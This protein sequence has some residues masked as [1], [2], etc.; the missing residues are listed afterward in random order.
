M[1]S[2]PFVDALTGLA[3]QLGGFAAAASPERLLREARSAAGRSMGAPPPVSAGAAVAPR[4]GG[5]P[6]EM[7]TALALAAYAFESYAEPPP[8][9]LWLTRTGVAAA[10]CPPAGDAGAEPPTE[11]TASAAR[12]RVAYPSTSILAGRSRGMFRL[13]IDRVE[14]S[15]SH[16]L[17]EGALFFQ[18]RYGPVV[19]DRPAYRRD[20]FLY[21]PSCGESA[22]GD[23]DAS[24]PTVPTAYIDVYSSRSAVMERRPLGTVALPL[25]GVDPEADVTGGLQDGVQEELSPDGVRTRLI[26]P[27]R[28]RQPG[29]PPP[30]AASPA[31][32]DGGSNPAAVDPPAEAD[33]VV[34]TVAVSVEQA[35][36]AGGTSDAPPPSLA[37]DHSIGDVMDGEALSPLKPNAPR[38][39]APPL[40]DAAARALALLG[41]APSSAAAMLADTA[42]EA[43]AAVDALRRAERRTSVAAAAA[44]A[45]AGREADATLAAALSSGMA[46]VVDVGYI[47]LRGGGAGEEV[48]AAVEAADAADAASASTWEDAEAAISATPMGEEWK[49]L[50]TEVMDAA[51][52]AHGRLC[53]TRLERAFFL[54]SDDTDT[55]VWIWRDPGRRLAVVAFRGTE[56][57]SWK[58]LATDAMAWQVPW[59]PADTPLVHF[60]FLRGYASVR[61]P[62]LAELSA[63]TGGLGRDWEVFFTGHSLGGA[64]AT[65]A[66][67]DVAAR[68]PGGRPPVLYS[69]GQPKVGDAAFGAAVDALLPAAFRVVNDVDVVARAPAGSYRHVGRAV[70]VN[71]A[72]QLALLEG[73]LTA[74]FCVEVGLG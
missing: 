43:A 64:L 38:P 48:E 57:V 58:D 59:V 16:A 23:D 9:S 55:E 62:L 30:A 46:L 44:A 65:L 29:A 37:S 41:G 35:I 6:F 74:L 73:T 17:F 42:R 32:L 3:D 47:P 63:L 10:D 40:T 69:F 24:P 12:V 49:A 72:G 18:V 20:F 22:G 25:G 71:A 52:S 14:R 34:P 51:E 26:V 11:G 13:A 19:V 27:I 4:A 5:P 67:A 33:A 15:W 70:L 50:A 1:S 39:P 28:L 60:G 45:A 66:A 2:L 68:H 53:H 7:T 21:A 56:T 8:G 31:L 61:E 36:S 54:E